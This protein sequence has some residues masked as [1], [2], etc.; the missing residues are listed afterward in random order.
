[1]VFSRKRIDGRLP[2]HNYVGSPEGTLDFYITHA[3]RHDRSKLRG[4][5]PRKANGPRIY[6]VPTD[7]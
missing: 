1:M 4:G 5:T 7:F 2:T 6:G 3:P